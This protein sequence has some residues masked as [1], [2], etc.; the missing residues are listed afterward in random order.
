MDRPSVGGPQMGLP[1]NPA[2]G[3]RPF[4][5]AGTA[6]L[7]NIPPPPPIPKTV[8][9]MPSNSG[10]TAPAPISASQ[11]IVLAREAMKKAVEENENQAAEASGVSNELKPG[12]TVNLS[13]KNIQKLPE[14]VVDLIKD[15][16]ERLALSHNKISTFPARFSEC[17]LLRYLNVRNNRI[18]EFPLQLCDLK[19]LE[20]LDL[21]RNQLRE[22]PPDIARLTS[23]KVFA[24]QKNVIKR[25]PLCLADMGSL[26]MIKLDGNPI[27]FPPKEILQ[28]QASSPPHDGYGKETEVKEV[29]VTTNI[30]KFLRQHLQNDRM[31]A[32]A[33]AF[34]AAAGEDSS[35][36]VETPRM[37][38]IKRVMSGRFPI[39]V[40]GTDVPDLRSP[41]TAI[42]PP[43]IPTRSHYRG[44]SQQ[45]TAIRRPGVM[46]LTIGNVNERL[47]SNS[48]NMLQVSRAQ[49]S[50][51]R[52]RRMASISK[53]TQELGTLDETQAN[54]RFSHYRGLSHG[55]AMQGPNGSVGSVKS[56]ASPADSYLQRPIYVRRLSVLPERKRESKYIDPV[57][58]TA[59]GVLYSVFQIHPMIQMLMGLASDGSPKRSSLEIVFYNTSVHVEELEQ[60]IQRHEVA[61]SEEIGLIENESAHR[62]CIT[63]VNA[64]AH[65][66]SLLAT[67]VDLFIENGD[68]RYIRTLLMQLYNSIMELRVTVSHPNPDAGYRRAA[69]RAAMGGTIR[70]PPHSRESSVTPTAERPGHGFRS[71]SGNFVHNPSN[72]RVA[73]DVPLN[74]LPVPYINGTGRTATITPT[75]RSGESWTSSTSSRGANGEF[76]EEERSFERIFLSLQ[77]SSDLIMRT[78]PV[79]NTQF[80]ACLDNA[81]ANNRPKA[82]QC[83]RMLIGKCNVAIQHTE[84]LKKCLSAIKLKEP[85][86]KT[87]SAL[88][89][90]CNNFMG[91]C[92]KETHNLI[93]SSPWEHS[94]RA[95][96]HSTSMSS[97]YGGGGGGG[98]G[99]SSSQGQSQLPMTPQSAALGP[100]VQATVPSTPQS[101]SFAGAFNGNVFERADALMAYGGRSMGPRTGTFSSHNSSSLSSI[102]STFS[103]ADEFVTPNSTMSSNMYNGG[104]LPLRLNNGSKVGF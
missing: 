92:V 81:M 55:S 95:H 90:L 36:G 2:Q 29:T 49:Q 50:G 71:R 35:E 78:L 14:E 67:N 61:E 76:N 42:R 53:R 21:G 97:A 98:G 57:L 12:V 9:K 83:W 60:E 54:N 34:A 99:G 62:A 13:H 10:L 70:P 28:A 1:G 46:P 33:A 30:K 17:T 75:P 85:G 88:W 68:P 82:K 23:L 77:R 79:L 37:P 84:A 45:N 15:Q 56:P 69:S 100:A 24:V 47:R 38:P 59:K 7:S 101:A 31:E 89:A 4:A 94:F 87:Y 41:N 52:Q 51:D 64:Y 19:S 80:G 40:N 91:A 27:Q 74:P 44:L 102:N 93:V 20:I 43:P 73:T 103:S 39:K 16:L 66:C 96:G 63:L 25:L 104:P 72:L 65:V 22:L 32:E 8:R 58:E 5:P 86:I 11:V 3:R 26:Q 6:G 48:E 18:T